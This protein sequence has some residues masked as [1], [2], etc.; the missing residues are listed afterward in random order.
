MPASV[1][2][3][4]AVAWYVNYLTGNGSNNLFRTPYQPGN[5]KPS[6]WLDNSSQYAGD[7]GASWALSD[8]ISFSNTLT[9]RQGAVDFHNLPVSG[10]CV[11][12]IRVLSD[13]PSDTLFT[14][15]SVTTSNIDN[16]WYNGS[17]G[18]SGVSLSP[19]ALTLYGPYSDCNSGSGVGTNYV[20]NFIFSFRVLNTD[21]N[22]LIIYLSSTV[23]S[24]N[25]PNLELQFH[26]IGGALHNPTGLSQNA[27]G[28]YNA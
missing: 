16:L 24:S 23:T 25:N 8:Y 18:S 10:V 12:V 14:V 7:G 22:R 20:G 6:K 17:G 19:G 3:S 15:V 5:A 1:F 28:V 11:A 9:P 21:T 2:Y 26:H 4:N 13:V 27:F